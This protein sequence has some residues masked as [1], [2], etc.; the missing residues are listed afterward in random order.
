MFFSISSSIL[1]A[2]TLSSIFLAHDHSSFLPNS[3]RFNISA[4]TRNLFYETTLLLEKVLIRV[5]PLHLPT[6]L[7]NTL[8]DDSHPRFVFGACSSL[9]KVLL[10]TFGTARST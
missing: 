7:S 2:F 5:P 1:R 9:T 10:L 3:G 4:L 6:M 8:N